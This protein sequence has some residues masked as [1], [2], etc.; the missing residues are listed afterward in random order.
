MH[1]EEGGLIDE[2]LFL[3]CECHLKM[4][5]MHTH[6]CARGLDILVKLQ[7]NPSWVGKPPVRSSS[8]R[9]GEVPPWIATRSSASVR[10]RLVAAARNTYAIGIGGLSLVSETSKSGAR[11]SPGGPTVSG[12]EAV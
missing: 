1:H 8:T 12:M 4:Q 7:A 11:R 3:V 5:L 9:C 2:K 6:P 10:S